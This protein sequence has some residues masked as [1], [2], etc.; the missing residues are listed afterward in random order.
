MHFGETELIGNNLA[1]LRHL[2]HY[3]VNS[4]MVMA[5]TELVS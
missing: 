1:N 3:G 5:I 2:D 4:V